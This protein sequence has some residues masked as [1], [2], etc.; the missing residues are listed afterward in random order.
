ML[1]VDISSNPCISEK[2]LA[3]IVYNLSF[4][5]KLRYLNISKCGGV[6]ATDLLESLYKLLRITGSLEVL[7]CSL[8]SGLNLKLN[9]EFFI[10]L[11]ENRTLHHLNLNN[12]GELSGIN[13]DLLGKATAFNAKKGGQLTI[14]NLRTNVSSYQ[15]LRKLIESMQI[16]NYDHECWFGDQ[17]K[18]NK[19]EGD[20]HKKIFY[21]QLQ[22][23]DVVQGNFASNFSLAQYK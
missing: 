11:G 9:R 23:L 7:D 8:I 22:N 17:N 15:N 1:Y 20:D 19:M 16:S 4:S 12:C 3:S 14:L 2:G 21:C 5:P 13:L 10:S 18:A 6:T